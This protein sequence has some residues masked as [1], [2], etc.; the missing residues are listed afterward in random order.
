MGVKNFPGTLLNGLYL[1]TMYSK[2]KQLGK[3]L[4]KFLKPYFS[5]NRMFVQSFVQD[6]WNVLFLNQS[7]TT[8]MTLHPTISWNINPIRMITQKSYFTP[9]FHFEQVNEGWIIAI[10][11]DL[12]LFFYVLS[13]YNTQVSVFILQVQVCW[14]MDTWRLNP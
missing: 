11:C 10:L 4:G 5:H 9:I 1:N 3:V 8:K 13:V 7:R 2:V 6:F 12:I 14:T